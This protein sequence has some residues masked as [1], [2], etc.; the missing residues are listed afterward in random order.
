MTSRIGR[1]RLWNGVLPDTPFRGVWASSAGIALLMVVAAAGGLWADGLY[2]DPEPF[3]A[4]LRG[5]DLVTLVVA[6][7]LLVGALL[8]ARHGSAG[9]QLVWLGMLAYAVYDYAIYVFGAA[10]NAFFL[11][12]VALFTGS[13]VTLGLAGARLD[14]HGVAARFSPRTPVRWI[15]GFLLLIAVG[16][17]GMW[18]AGALR[19]AFTGAFPGE[20]LMVL[21]P[22]AVHLAYALDLSLLVPAYVLAGILL[23]RRSAWGYVSASALLTFSTVYQLNY[24][25]G[26]RFQTWAHIPGAVS[27]D[28][29]ELPIVGLFAL[30]TVVMLGGL[31]GWGRPS[32]GEIGT[33]GPRG[34]R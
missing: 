3:A 6:A 28:Y 18:I 21:P 26:L 14:V 10:F 20:S 8:A 27:I 32:G 25:A 11:I 19:F 24:L 13:I 22:A 4:A 1:T 15:A 12:H 2:R 30:A 34:G 5:Y 17:G 33:D 7:P 23:W 31:R 29:Q 9:A 16:L